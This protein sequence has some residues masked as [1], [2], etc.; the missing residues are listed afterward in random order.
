MA[1]SA[2]P[3]SRTMRPRSPSRETPVS[4]TIALFDDHIRIIWALMLRELATR[5]GRDNAGFLWVIFEPLA[6]CLGVLALWRAIRGPVENGLSVVPFVMTGYMPL[7]LVRHMTMY[8]LNAVKINSGLLYHKS[9]TV[10]DLF[11]ARIVL[12]FIGVTFAFFIVYTL[13]L[14]FGFAKMP[15]DVGLIYQ[16]W[17]LAG[18]AGGGLALLVGGISEI[19]EV[20][21]RI[22]GIALYLLVP[23]SGTFFLADWLPPDVRRVALLLPFLNCAEMIRAG[24]F[25]TA[26]NAHYDA[27]YTFTFDWVMIVLGLLL[28]RRIRDRVDVL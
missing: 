27:A 12:E 8:S 19:F 10:L 9:I 23:L 6:F 25:G 11:S 4:K 5:Y 26:I 13:L 15:A 22:I 21:E 28:I 24:M 14:I 1:A 2:K 18:M 7:I 20:V 17:L 3:T 16:G